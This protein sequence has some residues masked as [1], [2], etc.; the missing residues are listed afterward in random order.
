MS[1]DAWGIIVPLTEMGRRGRNMLREKD[2]KF[3]WGSLQ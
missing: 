1:Q 3:V 2:D